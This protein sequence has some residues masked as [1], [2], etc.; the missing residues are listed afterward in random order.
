VHIINYQCDDVAIRSHRE[1]DCGWVEKIRG[2]Y[3][4]IGMVNYTM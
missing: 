3:R 4:P 2:K 1:K